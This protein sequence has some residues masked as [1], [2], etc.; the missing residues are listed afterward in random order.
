MIQRENVKVRF[1]STDGS[2]VHL[3]LIIIRK[4]NREDHCNDQNMENLFKN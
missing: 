1:Q 3:G 4:I 2:T